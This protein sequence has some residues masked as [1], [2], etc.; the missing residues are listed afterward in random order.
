MKR[1]VN[2]F[3]PS[4]NF[5]QL[6]CLFVIFTPSHPQPILAWTEHLSSL[7]AYTPTHLDYNFLFRIAEAIDLFQFKASGGNSIWVNSNE[8]FPR[9]LVCQTLKLFPKST[10]LR[11]LIILREITKTGQN[12][13]FI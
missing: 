3:E 7:S 2:L 8:F 10:D 11:M 6:M 1:E 13:K 5:T 9:L 4:K 12:D